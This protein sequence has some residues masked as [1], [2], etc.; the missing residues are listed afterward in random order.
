MIIAMLNPCWMVRRIFARTLCTLSLAA[1][2]GPTTSTWADA[3]LATRELSEPLAFVKAFDGDSM[4]LR[5]SR[6]KTVQ[7]RLVGID[8]PEKTQAHGQAARERLE[9]LLKAEQIEA[10][11][12]KRDGHGRW[13][14]QLSVE[15]RDIGQTMIVEGHAWYFRRYRADLT[16]SARSRYE[17]AEAV[18]REERRGL[19]ASDDEP[20]PPWRYREKRR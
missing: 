19:W 4:L 1:I 13:I 18:A 6:G 16:V 14:A 2:L 8:A 7:V 20:I 9:S 3:P 10:K 5:N 11:A 17:E 12:V 15:G